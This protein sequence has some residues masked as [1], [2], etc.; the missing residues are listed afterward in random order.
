MT[1]A[2]LVA[3][4]NAYF[5]RFNLEGI[6]ALSNNQIAA[7]LAEIKVSKALDTPKIPQDLPDQ[8]WSGVIA[9]VLVICARERGIIS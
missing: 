6:G 9:R 4:P 8:F 7:M 5:S 2:E 1:F 3:K